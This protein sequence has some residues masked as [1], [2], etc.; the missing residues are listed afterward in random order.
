VR[1]PGLDD[2]A[3][4]V[5][6]GQVALS[7]DGSLI[8]Y[9]RRSVVDGRDRIAL[10][11][12]PFEGG[13]PRPLTDGHSDTLPRFSPDGRMLAFVSSRKPEEDA[14]VHVVE[15][16][17]GIPWRLTEFPHGVGDL[18]WTPDGAGL[19]VSAA[20][21]HGAGEVPGPEGAATAFVI[22]RIDWRD[23]D[24]P[25]VPRRTT[26]LHLVALDGGPPR[27]LTE[28]AWSAWRPRVA[29]D[30]TVRREELLRV[31][32]RLEALHLPLT[33]AGWLVRILGAVIQVPALP[34]LGA[35]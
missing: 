20:D 34:M 22:E 23:D 2:L 3:R 28:G 25:S 9:T 11:T 18:W 24:D 12:V 13:A 10:W 4:Q 35:G 6:I 1:P 15:L 7:P 8:A 17:R 27:R 26:H 31:P 21:E 30:G 33:P 14:Q 32:G 29:A 16:A 19:V 5:A